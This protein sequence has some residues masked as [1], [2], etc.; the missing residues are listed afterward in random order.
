MKDTWKLYIKSLDGWN[1]NTVQEWCSIQPTQKLACPPSRN[2]IRK[3]FMGRQGTNSQRHI[4]ST[5]TWSQST[6]ICGFQSCRWSSYWTF[7][8]IHRILHFHEYGS[9]LVVVPKTS[10]HPNICVLSWVGWYETRHKNK[11]WNTVQTAY[12][13]YCIIRTIILVWRQYVNYSQNI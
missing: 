12:D 11:A 9:N 1:V 10:N 5:W 6:T 2:A 8:F 13:G 7:T 3:N 4:I